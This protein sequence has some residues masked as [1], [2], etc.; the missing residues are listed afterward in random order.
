[1]Q[2]HQ[3]AA[4][5]LPIRGY[6][7]RARTLAVTGSASA[8]ET[9]TGPP[10]K[11]REQTSSISVRGRTAHLRFLPSWCQRCI[12]PASAV[13]PNGAC[14][15]RSRGRP[16]FACNDQKSRYH[17]VSF[18]TAG[19]VPGDKLEL[20]TDTHQPEKTTTEEST[21]FQDI[22]GNSSTRES[23]A[24]VSHKSPLSP[25]L[26]DRRQREPDGTWQHSRTTQAE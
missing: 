19:T 8:D 9:K 13:C 10:S 24:F 3:L 22:A 16:V 7:D 11:A 18:P 26:Y 17:S 6:P 12:S 14:T 25:S 23:P 4:S 15:Q 21:E 5:P 2:I 1:M 20:H